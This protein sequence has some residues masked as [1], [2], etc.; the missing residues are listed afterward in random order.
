MAP[1]FGTYYKTGGA[2][3]IKPTGK[4]AEAQALFDQFEADDRSRQADRARQAADQDGH[5][6]SLDH[7]HRGHGSRAVVKNNFRNVPEKY[8]QD[9]IIF[10][11]ATWIPATSSSRNNVK[12]GIVLSGDDPWQS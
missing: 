5:R 10:S 1:A 6:R 8:T 4:L 3:G 2:Q 12:I 11:Q 9:W 7:Q